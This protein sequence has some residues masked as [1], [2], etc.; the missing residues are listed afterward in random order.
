MVDGQFFILIL[1][2]FYQF[3]ENLHFELYNTKE[4]YIIV[5]YNNLQEN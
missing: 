3:L 2:I 5:I 4:D 1:C